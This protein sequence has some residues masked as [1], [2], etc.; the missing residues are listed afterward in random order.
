MSEDLAKNSA[1]PRL[2][3]PE[4]L[5]GTAAWLASDDAGF[6][7]GQVVSVSGGLSLH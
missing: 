1:I 6:V 2:E 4:D 3:C 5:A 7:T